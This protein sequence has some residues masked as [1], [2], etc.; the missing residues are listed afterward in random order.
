M[1]DDRPEA[2]AYAPICRQVVALEQCLRSSPVVCRLLDTLP[3]LQLPSWYIGAGAVAQTVW[4]HLH[5]FSP[6]HGVKDYDVVYFDPDDLTPDGEQAVEAKVA[7]LLDS[8]VTVD[9]TNEARVHTWYQRR[10]GLPLMP[11]RSTEHAIATW[12]STATSVGVRTDGDSLDVC[13]PYGLSDLFGLVVR[14]NTTL[15]SREV[16]EEKAERWRQ[17]W[18]L[19]AV[20]AWPTL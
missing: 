16:Y 13:A 7:G 18:P 17:L 6:S 20:L 9:V 11:Y 3:A 2:L 1:S 10:F 15:V 5:D 14:P 12:P 19:L 4:N 8:A